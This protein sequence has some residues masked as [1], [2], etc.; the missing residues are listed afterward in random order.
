MER[1]THR[2]DAQR[3]RRRQ[4]LNRLLRPKQVAFIGGKAVEDS[5]TVLLRAGYT[6]EIWPVNPKYDMLAGYPCYKSVADLPSPPDAALLAVSRQLTVKVIGQLADCGA[7]GAV[8]VTGEFAES[9]EL[10]IQLQLDLNEAAGDL[11]LVGPN[12]LGI[13]NLFDHVAVWGGD[14]RFEP[15][16][17]QGVALISQSGY[18]AYSITNVEEAFPLGYAISMGN[19]AVLDVSDFIEVLLDDE[20]V[21][22][23]GI[24]LEELVDV[25]ALS[26]AAL[27]AFERGVPIVVLKAGGTQ[28][29]AKL[30][31]SHSGTLA[32]ANDLWRA[33]F[34][35]LGMVEVKSPKALVEAMKILGI[36]ER[37]CGPRLVAAANSGG[38]SALI[39]EQGEQLGLEFP[40]PTA[41]QRAALR[42]RLPDLVSLSNPLDYNLP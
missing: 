34:E 21:T 23:I 9:D 13:L 15:A 14:N 2:D 31:V 11:A 36:L 28:K 40:V 27:R 22:A 25:A 8:S 20:R 30:T 39:A 29:S 3:Q 6:G 4:N 26:M 7:G 24:Y 35:R 16:P 12:C 42:E 33:L 5:I 32:V 18:V 1:T 38:Y 41:L 10:G 19:Q 17:E 37:P